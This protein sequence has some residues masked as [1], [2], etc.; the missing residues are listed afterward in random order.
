ML[1]PDDFEPTGER[2]TPNKGEYFRPLNFTGDEVTDEVYQQGVDQANATG[3]RTILRPK[4]NS[5]QVREQLEQIYQEL[6]PTVPQEPVCS[7]PSLINGHHNGCEYLAWRE[8]GKA[9]A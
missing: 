3:A 4:H 9:N 1:N 5:A 6:K 7:C 2:R 8:H